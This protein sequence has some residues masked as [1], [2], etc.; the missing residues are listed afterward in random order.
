MYMILSMTG[1]GKATEHFNDKNIIVELRALN[2]KNLDLKT[3]MPSN[4]RELEM[5]IR[6]MLSQLL[7]RGK[8][9]LNIQIEDL[10]DRPKNKINVPVLK[11]YLADLNQVHPN[12]DQ[13][14]L[15]AAALRLPDVL[16]PEEDDLSDGEQQAV[17]KALKEASGL[18]TRYRKDEGQALEN[19]LKLRLKNISKALKDIEQLDTER[20]DKI[21]Q[22]LKDA[23]SQLQQ[24]VDQN[25]FEQ[26]LIYYLE[27]LD[28]NEEKVRLK[29]HLQYFE[30]ELQKPDE[31]KGK[32]LGFIS[33]E[34][35]REINTIG[36][37]ANDSQ[38][39]RK[40]VRMKDELEKIKEQVLNV[41]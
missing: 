40:V 9:D 3:R 19:D 20:L 22:R 41:L 30:K 39:Q 17:M 1:Y 25:R 15:M 8:V 36:S 14:I 34:I 6:K 16:K 5:P 32:K 26:E 29:N 31:M 7:K 28:I 24:E 4:Y 23:L 33:Q 18:L 38:I 27:K 12:A 2:S 10:E 21:K 35:G 11:Q 37:K 13:S